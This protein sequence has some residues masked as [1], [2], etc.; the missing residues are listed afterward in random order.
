MC[1]SGGGI[2]G[3][4]GWGHLQI[5]APGL[6][7]VKVCCGS[8]FPGGSDP[9]KM[10][11][12]IFPLDKR[13]KKKVTPSLHLCTVRF[14]NI[15]YS[16]KNKIDFTFHKI[17]PFK[18]RSSVVFSICTELGKPSPLSNSRTSSPKEILYFNLTLN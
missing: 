4:D 14:E 12:V 8:F 9:Q 3:Q 7:R 6:P 11:H 18:L 1:V 10:L 15:Y 2:G 16:L 13:K 17:Y 5:T